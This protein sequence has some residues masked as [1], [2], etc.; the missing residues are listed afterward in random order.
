MS[1]GLRIYLAS[2]YT[3]C[4]STEEE[5]LMAELQSI[6]MEGAPG[7]IEEFEAKLL[8]LSGTADPKETLDCIFRA[9][10]SMKGSAAS[11]GF[12][13]LASF[14][15]K[16]EDCLSIL[17]N[18]P[19]LLGKDVV[20]VLLQSL[21]IM[22]AWVEGLKNRGASFTE[23]SG[24]LEV[25]NLLESTTSA[26]VGQETGKNDQTI[27]PEM[28]EAIEPAVGPSNVKT[29][30]IKTANT[31]KVDSDRVDLVM[32]LVGELVVIKSQLL[33]DATIKAMASPRVESVLSLL[34]K[35]VR[36]LYDKALSL[37]MTSL[38]S[39]FLRV[40]RAVRDTSIKVEKEVVVTTD[41]SETELD[42]AIIDQLGDPLMHLARNAVDHGIE[43]PL[44]RFDAGKPII[45][46]LRV[47]ARNRGS[48]VVIEISDDGRGL[49]PEKIARKA[50]EKGLVNPKE[51]QGARAETIYRLMFLPGFSTAEKVTDISG[52]GVGLDVVK[53]AVESLK[54][55]IEI[56]SKSG[57]GTTFRLVLPLT[58]AILDGVIVRVG[59]HRYILPIELISEFVNL[60]PGMI[61]TVDAGKVLKIRDN[62]IPAISLASNFGIESG[63]EELAVIVKTLGR[64]IGLLVDEVAQQSQVV[65][66]SLNTGQNNIPGVS[67]AAILGDGRV[68]LVLDPAGL[69]NKNGSTLGL[70]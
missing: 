51:I 11:V 59:G 49:D 29:S 55:Q 67:G 61:T 8:A 27:P 40:E 70:T 63:D 48:N 6:F 42:R 38:K 44:E 24:V 17:R 62:F 13:T 43:D 50:I 23:P 34:D 1:G 65:L 32:D 33:Q 16:T 26:L 31:I 5:L 7:I 12:T 36:E 28:T 19:E 53:T 60:R 30:K 45:G 35:T 25:K 18:K 14:A 10:H 2:P 4:M 3:S 57:Q 22:K 69:T 39:M 68:A 20:S 41:G 66:K 64:Q 21:D 46:S 47:S 37:R 52:R 58:T 54:G 9:A 15:H 56:D